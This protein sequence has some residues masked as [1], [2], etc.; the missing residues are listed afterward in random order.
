MAKSK[1]APQRAGTRNEKR[2]R[3]V[4]ALLEIASI[5]RDEYRK[6]RAE[7]WQAVARSHNRKP[8]KQLREWSARAS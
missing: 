1:T 2:A 7:M 4:R 8:P 6:L 3:L 5:D